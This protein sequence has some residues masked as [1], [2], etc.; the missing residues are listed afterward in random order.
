MTQPGARFSGAIVGALPE[1][2][3]TSSTT[4][5]KLT[6]AVW[7]LA[8]EVG[9]QQWEEAL[10]PTRDELRKNATDPPAAGEVTEPAHCAHY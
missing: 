2:L 5:T 7:N 4:A 3:V 8:L 6:T 10:S 1:V 9:D